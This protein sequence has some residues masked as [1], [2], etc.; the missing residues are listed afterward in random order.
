MVLVAIGILKSRKQEK[1]R[2][3]FFFLWFL[4]CLL[5][6]IFWPWHKFSFYLTVPL[7]GLVSFFAILLKN[8]PKV[9]VFLA[10]L[11][12]FAVSLTTVRIS[13]GT[14][15]VISRAKIAKN[16]IT[17]LKS[18]YPELPRGASLYFQNDPDYPF[19]AALWGNASTQAY[20]AL[21]GE[22]AAQVIYD[23]KTLKVYFEDLGKPSEEEGVF[24][25]VAR[26][27]Q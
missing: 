26:I 9:L 8:L 1:K 11:L 6:V 4:I 17:D 22:N 7:L 19:I 24:P 25:I 15:W 10:I 3:A 23:D 16:L 2:Q 27:S 14:Y 18:Q 20:Y 13:Q 21:S 12:L 5:P